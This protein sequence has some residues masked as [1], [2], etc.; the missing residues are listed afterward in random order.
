MGAEEMS[1]QPQFII[2]HFDL[3][4][5][6]G[7]RCLERPPKGERGPR[8]KDSVPVVPEVRLP[9]VTVMPPNAPLRSAVVQAGSMCARH[10]EQ[11]PR[12]VRPVPINVRVSMGHQIVPVVP[13]DV[14]PMVNVPVPPVI[15]HVVAVMSIGV[16]AVVHII[17]RPGVATVNGGPV[18]PEILGARGCRDA[19]CGQHHEPATKQCPFHLRPPFSGTPFAPLPWGV[20]RR[21][22]QPVPKEK[23]GPSNAKEDEPRKVPKL[24]RAV[25]VR[26]LLEFPPVAGSFPG[27]PI[28]LSFPQIAALCRSAESP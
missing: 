4:G 24:I 14:V 27:L 25:Y 13:L 3:K 16:I 28:F 5:A 22:S 19:R 9:A 7:L 17:D 23:R 11:D 26:F 21:R 15:L 20:T 18:V 1:A 6:V 8:I 2:S 12:A 10:V